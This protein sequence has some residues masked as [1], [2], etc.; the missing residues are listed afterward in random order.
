MK[1]K[2]WIIMIIIFVA[3]KLFPIFL[4][5]FEY[6][7]FNGFKVTVLIIVT[8]IFFGF[9][10]YFCQKTITEKNS[11]GNLGKTILVFMIIIISVKIVS[12]FFILNL[13]NDVV[14]PLV[15]LNKNLL[16][17]SSFSELREKENIVHVEK[18]PSWSKIFYYI[19]TI[20]DLKI[21]A[22]ADNIVNN[23][24]EVSDDSYVKLKKNYE[25]EWKATI[26]D[27][28]YAMEEISEQTYKT[29]LFHCTYISIF[30]IITV[31]IPV[32]I[33]KKADIVK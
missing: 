5:I 27:W 28:I 16:N 30:Q 4:R 14:N 19:Y 26:E 20:N 1:L 29:M 24:Q 8:C 6:G 10:Y 25:K 22:S 2:N 11:I 21:W 33:N 3:V 15:S 17:Y 7:I 13:K 32:Y 23:M 9:Y 12:L 31:L 18:L